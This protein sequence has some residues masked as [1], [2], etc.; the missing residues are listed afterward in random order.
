VGA[1]ETLT[2]TLADESGLEV[3]FQ[4][5]DGTLD[6]AALEPGSY[7]LHAVKTR[8]TTAGSPPVTTVT[9]VND[10]SGT[11][12]VGPLTLTDVEAEALEGTRNLAAYALEATRNEAVQVATGGATAADHSWNDYDGNGWRL[13]SNEGGGVWTRYFYDAR[14]NVAREV[15]FQRRARLDLMLQAWK[16]RVRNWRAMCNFS[17]SCLS[18]QE[19]RWKSLTW[20]RS[21]AT[22]VQ[23]QFLSRQ[24]AS[25]GS[26]LKIGLQ[27]TG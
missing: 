11:L 27:R 14:G 12:V 5:A 24:I 19:E 15:R 18:K 7:Q 22:Q 13:F 25:S 17:A 21:G 6:V 23:S 2:F 4:F 10:I 3:P 16:R 26:Q 1:D 8:S 9:T 20:L